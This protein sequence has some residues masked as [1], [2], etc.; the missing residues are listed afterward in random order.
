MEKPVKW[1]AEMVAIAAGLRKAGFTNAV[2]S[3]RL[4]ISKSAVQNKLH[5][6]N[7]KSGLDGKGFRRRFI[8]LGRITNN[9][10]KIHEEDREDG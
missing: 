5:K 9:F 8:P 1:T 3:E 7:V 4:G 10:L 6:L 2:I